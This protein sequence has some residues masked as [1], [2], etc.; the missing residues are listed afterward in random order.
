[1]F[2]HFTST[3]YVLVNAYLNYTDIFP[4]MQYICAK[5]DSTVKSAIK[6]KGILRLEKF[7]GNLRS[8]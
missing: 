5:S 7:L 2:L 6:N 4:F 3:T 1:M 8:N